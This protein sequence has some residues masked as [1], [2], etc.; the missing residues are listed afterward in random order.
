[1][2]II[3]PGDK[4][5]ADRKEAVKV[6]SQAAVSLNEKLQK[7]KEEASGLQTKL[8]SLD[9][10]LQ[11]R[12][13]EKQRLE[14]ELEALRGEVESN[15]SKMKDLEEALQERQSTLSSLEQG[16]E[17][18]KEK[19]RDLQG[20]L[21]AAR[22]EVEWTQ[23]DSMS[24]AEQIEYFEYELLAKNQ[25]VDDLKQELDTRLRRIIELEVD[26]EIHDD[27]FQQ[28]QQQVMLDMDE[29]SETGTARSSDAGSV[30]SSIVSAPSA[31]PRGG[32]LQKR[33]SGLG[34]MLKRRKRGR[35]KDSNAVIQNMDLAREGGGGITGEG[36]EKIKAELAS[37]ESRYKKEKY[38]S[39]VQ[40]QQ[41]KQESN[42]YLI[43][44]LGLEK[45][46]QK[47][48]DASHADQQEAAQAG[49]KGGDGS[50]M[51]S[52]DN[53]DG[54][55]DNSPNKARFLE[56]RV[57]KLEGEQVL[58]DREMKE[59]R[60]ELAQL[61]MDASSRVEKD[62]LTI[63][64]LKLENESKAAKIAGLEH[65]LRGSSRAVEDMGAIGA[66]TMG[67]ESKINDQFAELVRLRKELE[68]RE[69]KVEKLR[70]EIIQLRMTRMGEESQP[71]KE[72][73]QNQQGLESI[74]E[75]GGA[76]GGAGGAS[77]SVSGLSTMAV[78]DKLAWATGETSAR[79]AP[80]EQDVLSRINEMDINA[81]VT[82]GDI[83]RQ[84]HV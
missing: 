80:I 78:G 72:P 51:P 29:Q 16:H 28:R 64:K 2:L 70:T 53:Q 48:R 8:E 13:E 38:N 21:S 68:L 52:Q 18:Y 83:R 24:K 9:S 7:Q 43:K 42:D 25:E 63:E 44:V 19:E 31:S 71:A 75:E 11:T 73:A 62:R 54:G 39:R 60:D 5:E 81:V 59:L 50:D 30:T 66:T 17:E 69:R 77:R 12:E 84:Y 65:Q 35:K 36:A 33:R 47:A 45:S 61:R 27:R 74:H 6:L 57:K 55:A 40:I 10:T 4:D 58:K 41:L 3:N 1:M 26:L 23:K 37:L 14:S 15:Q 34:A 82:L 22:E 79:H 49:E 56:E 32:G 67:L 20:R 46:L 76:G